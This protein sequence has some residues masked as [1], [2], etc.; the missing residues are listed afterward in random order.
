MGGATGAGKD[1]SS[2]LP[3]ARLVGGGGM[4]GMQESGERGK[5]DVGAEAKAEIDGA[6]GWMTSGGRMMKCCSGRG[7]GEG[8]A[9]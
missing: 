5:L 8:M 2:A 6:G 1:S 3:C 4:A 9:K 7:A